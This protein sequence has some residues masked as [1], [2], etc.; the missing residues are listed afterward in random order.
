MTGVYKSKLRKAKLG[1]IDP[2]SG[3]PG[4]LDR[5]LTRNEV[6]VML[7]APFDT[8]LDNPT[9]NQVEKAE[10]DHLIIILLWESWARLN[11]LLNVHVEHIDLRNRTLY[12]ATPKRKAK[13]DRDGNPY[14][15][16][17]E[18]ETGFTEETKRKLIKYLRGRKKG[19]LFPL[20]PRAVR[21]LVKDYA[22][23]TGVQKVIGY[24]R[25]GE[26]RFLIC[27]K[28]FREAGEF[29]ACADGMDDAMAATR[30]GHT[31]KVQ[32]KNYK[33]KN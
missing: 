26:P 23:A 32:K 12:I 24:T 8:L 29:Y 31:E 27:P 33:K 2:A 30:A 21:D 13:R 15:E 6:K 19:L 18:R 16:T 7:N 9:P 25:K 1:S 22:E 20:T 28:A 4:T 5:G 17:V 10:R 3:F 14:S 11:E